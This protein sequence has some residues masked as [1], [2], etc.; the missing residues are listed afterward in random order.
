VCFGRVQFVSNVQVIA[1]RLICQSPPGSMNWGGGRSFG[2]SSSATRFV[3]ADYPLGSNAARKRSALMRVTRTRAFALLT[4]ALLLA[5]HPS[6]GVC[7]SG[8][9]YD[10]CGTGVLPPHGGAVWKLHD[11]GGYSCCKA[12]G[13]TNTVLRQ[14]QAARPVRPLTIA[15]IPPVTSLATLPAVTVRSHLSFLHSQSRVSFSGR[16]R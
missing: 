12:Q 14:A 2:S 10:S 4:I 3:L 13:P 15:G 11:A 8:C 9:D 5:I 1:G 6:H 16:C 7:S